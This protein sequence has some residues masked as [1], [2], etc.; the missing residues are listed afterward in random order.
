MDVWKRVF[1]NRCLPLK[2]LWENLRTYVLRAYGVYAA[3]CLYAVLCLAIV[4][5]IILTP[6]YPPLPPPPLESHVRTHIFS[7]SSRQMWSAGRVSTTRI[8]S[9]AI[10][11]A[12]T[13]VSR[14]QGQWRSRLWSC[15][16]SPFF[17]T[18]SRIFRNFWKTDFHRLNDVINDIIMVKKKKKKI[19]VF[20]F[21]PS[22]KLRGGI[23]IRSFRWRRFLKKKQVKVFRKRVKKK[24]QVI[25]IFE[26]CL[27]NG[28]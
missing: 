23:K 26:N 18:N 16:R 27:E 25:F 13:K 28:C 7:L 20:L 12:R 8:H 4:L 6:P 15:L 11:L 22:C 2:P 9:M 21:D 24:N 3:A 19:N 14:F 17:R 5:V 1:E 10:I